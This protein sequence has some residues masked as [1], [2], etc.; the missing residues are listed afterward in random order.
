MGLSKLGSLFLI[1]AFV[2][3]STVAKAQG[4]GGPIGPVPGPVGA[5]VVVQPQDVFEQFYRLSAQLQ[6]ELGRARQIHGR[7][8]EVFYAHF[9]PMLNY[10]ANRAPW[11]PAFYNTV[12]APIPLPAPIRGQSPDDMMIDYRVAETISKM[13][14]HAGM[15]ADV[16]LNSYA[17]V[18]QFFPGLDIAYHN[19]MAAT[20]FY[21]EVVRQS[22]LIRG[23]TPNPL[24]GMK[25]EMLIKQ[26]CKMQNLAFLIRDLM[27]YIRMNMGFGV[28]A[29]GVVVCHEWQYRMY[30]NIPMAGPVG[31]PFLGFPYFNQAGGQYMG[32]PV[33]APQGAPVTSYN[34]QTWQGRFDQ[35]D[36][37]LQG[38]GMAVPQGGP[39][40]GAPQGGMPVEGGAGLPQVP[41]QGQGIPQQG[42]Q[43]PPQQFGPAYGGQGTGIPAQGYGNRGGQALPGGVGRPLPG[44]GGYNNGNG[45]GSVT[46][47]RGGQ[48]VPP[49]QQAPA[50][51]GQGQG[52]PLPENDGVIPYEQQGQPRR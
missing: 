15:V 34:P 10:S 37:Y 21:I 22:F 17:Q 5:A 11:G 31:Q 44:N 27:L 9:R 35:F 47:P 33:Q 20:Y 43:V 39:A 6:T 49:Q 32:V 51:G 30:R 12:L 38:D 16:S 45:R 2:L 23:I 18:P 41:P 8:P 13:R 24:V 36:G 7:L 40:P 3:A 29:G 52:T 48:Q 19:A 25:K 46:A 1:T 14:E 26:L 4:P 42:G 28:P 50:N